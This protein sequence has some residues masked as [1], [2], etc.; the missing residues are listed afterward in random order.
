MGKLDV[1]A[2]PTVIAADIGGDAAGQ[3]VMNGP[4]DSLDWS[5]VR[6]KFRQGEIRCTG[7]GR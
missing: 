6:P 2:Q 5:D 4:K 7:S 3:V 1:T